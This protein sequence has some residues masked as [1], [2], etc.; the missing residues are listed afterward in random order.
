MQFKAELNSDWYQKDG[1]LYNTTMAN[2]K[3]KAGES[4]N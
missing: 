1:K 2:K 3:I 4:Q